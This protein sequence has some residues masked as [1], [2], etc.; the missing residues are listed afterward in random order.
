[1]S[2]DLKAFSKSKIETRTREVPVPA[3][4]DFFGEDEAPIFKVRALEHSEVSKVR[5]CNQRDDLVKS[6]INALS[7][8]DSEKSKAIREILG[9]VQEVPE[10]TRVRIEAI[11]IACVEPEID[12]Q[13]AVKIAQFFPNV[14]D[15]L[16][17]IIFELTDQGGVIAKKKPLNSGTTQT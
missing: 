8:S 13:L 14:L 7:G 11:K 6:A 15:N 3:L 10:R 17:E 1:M 12:Q 9:D 5:E 16:T 4:S 2:F